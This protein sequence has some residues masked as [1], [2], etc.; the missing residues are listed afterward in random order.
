MW[1]SSAHSRRARRRRDGGMTAYGGGGLGLVRELAEALAR[2]GSLQERGSRALC[3]RLMA[4]ELGAPPPV[5]EH[6]V[7]HYFLL[8]LAWACLENPRTMRALHEA[9][10][11]LNEDVAELR[12]L[13]DD[14]LADPALPVG[15]MMTLRPLL[16]G[17]A[18]PNLPDLCRRAAGGLRQVPP[19]D[20]AWS[21]FEGL[22]RLNARPDGLPTTMAFVEYVAAEAPYERGIALRAWNDAQAHGLSLLTELRSLRQ[23]VAYAHSP[24]PGNAYLVVRLL[25]REEPGRYR[26]TS[27]RHYD[28][29]EP[30]SWRPAQEAS[31]EV[32]LAEAEREV[33]RLVFEADEDWA[34]DAD[35]IHVEFALGQE[36]LNLPVHRFRIEIDSPEPASL[37]VGYCVV[38]RSLTRCR[39]PRWHR[40]W[41]QR[42]TSLS[43]TPELA[44][45]LVMGGPGHDDPRCDD[46][47]SLDAR[48]RGDRS[49]GCLLLSGP[50]E[51]ATDSAREALI[52]LRCGLP[53]LLWDSRDV[54][55]PRGV[56]QADDRIYGMLHDLPGLREAVTQLRTE[57]HGGSLNGRDNHPGHH[58]VLLFDDP[59]RP[60]ESHQPLAGP[61]QGV[62]GR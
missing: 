47:P 33:E 58:L 27:W 6:D 22:S 42:W 40:A 60:I 32:T 53:A 15:E 11:A 56:V 8:E 29:D 23:Q 10:T 45:P 24:E 12:R 57:A 20:D 43:R 16:D 46:L 7:A 44:R 55:T 36:D 25:R 14:L 39:T 17:F 1:Q 61:D 35:R 4:K 50:P 9:L 52:A 59:T 34:R 28:P 49:I 37:G 54:T 38:V 48:L 13:T 18:L 19:Y 26:L 31:V 3:L 51:P 5:R 62:G 2:C 30:T 21:A 41:K